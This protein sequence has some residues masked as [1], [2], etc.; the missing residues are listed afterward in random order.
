MDATKWLAIVGVASALTLGVGFVTGLISVGLGWKVNREQKVEMARANESAADAKLKAEKLEGDNLTLRGQVATLETQATDAKKDV[1][2]LQKA[3]SDAL[4]EQQRVQTQLAEQQ[5][6]TASLEKAATDAK[7]SQQ[8]VET[9]LAK[10]KERTAKA[11]KELAEVQERFK[12]RDLNQE[13]SAQLVAFLKQHPAG[14]V[15]VTAVGNNDES[16]HFAK[17]L[18][19]ILLEAGWKA[20]WSSG[21]DA[22]VPR[23]LRIIVRDATHTNGGFIQKGL[24]ALGFPVPGIENP[25]R[26]DDKVTLSVGLKP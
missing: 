12:F 26:K 17:Q 8:R 7:A 5:G 4:A 19:A 23:G 16:E 18:T 2:G 21:F 10:Q 9:D 22:N 24:D 6:R 13:Q 3:A 20:H 15:E 25:K 1:A 11:E 14:E